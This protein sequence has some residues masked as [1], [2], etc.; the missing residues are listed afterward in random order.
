MPRKSAESGENNV[1]SKSENAEI[2]VLQDQMSSVQSALIDI[3]SDTKSI[4]TSLATLPQN[5]VSKTEFE[6]FKKELKAA[7]LTKTVTYILV[8][9]I[10]TSMAYALI[11]GRTK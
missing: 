4:V 3:R 5:Y 7:N 2:A 1:A 6:T 11:V 9:A 10:I 8:T